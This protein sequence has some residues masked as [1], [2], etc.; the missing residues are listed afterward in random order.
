[1]MG[2]LVNG[3]WTTQ[4]PKVQRSGTAGEFIRPDSV[5]RHSIRAD[6]SSEFTPSAG[7]Y[8]LYVAHACPWANRVLIMRNLK[9]L[10][11]A[12]SVSYVAPPM[13]ADGWVFDDEHPDELLGKR[14]LR[15]VYTTAD[16]SYT[17]RVTVPILWDKESS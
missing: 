11:D 9:G 12:I 14:F 3:T 6:G 7:R 13:G 15:D 1:M 16:P 17:G 4:K 5:H 2:W 8:H 10:R